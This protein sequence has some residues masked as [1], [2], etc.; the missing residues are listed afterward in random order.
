MLS[1]YRKLAGSDQ[2]L[3]FLHADEAA[4]ASAMRLFLDVTNSE[5]GD[6]ILAA[7]KYLGSD[8]RAN[9]FATNAGLWGFWNGEVLNE[10]LLRINGASSYAVQVETKMPVIEERMNMM[11]RVLAGTDL[12]DNIPPNFTDTGVAMAFPMGTAPNGID[13]GTFVTVRDNVDGDIDFS[14]VA[15]NASDVN[16]GRPGRYENAVSLSVSD[17]AGNERT[18]QRTVV[19]FDGGNRVPPRIEVKEGFRTLRLGEETRF[20]NWGA[21]FVASAVD[22]DGL[23]VSHSLVANL[24][25][26]DTT[27]AGDYDVTLSV[28]DYADNEN[29]VV[30]TV[31]VAAQ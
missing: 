26:L 4:R 5:Y 2:A 31:T 30:I 7:W 23:D 21:D 28:K 22:R 29:S 3:D 20:I 24:A 9:E 11:Q 15:V 12:I 8:A 18:V 19:V 1:Y 14:K 27:E 25:E 6:K 17:T 16:F 10:S 13:W